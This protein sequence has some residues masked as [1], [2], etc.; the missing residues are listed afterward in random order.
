MLLLSLMVVVVACVAPAVL[1]HDGMI[2]VKGG[3]FTMGTDD[4]Q[5]RDG[6]GPARRVKVKTFYLDEKPVVNEQFRS[7][8]RDTKYKTDAEKYGWSFVF[9]A[10]VADEVKSTIEQTVK[11][12]EWWL[13]VPK[14]YWRVP[15][16]KGSGLKNKMDYPVTQVSWNDA[17]AYCKW[18]GKRLPTEAEWEFAVRGGLEGKVYPWGNKI[19]KNRM[20]TWEGKFPDENSV[21]DGHHGLAPADA[22]GP[23]NKFGF[24]NMLGNGWEWTADEFQR[25]ANAPPQ[26]SQDKQYVLRGGS[27]L[28]SIDGKT[29]HKVRVTTRMGNTPD[30]GSDNLTFRC[31][32]SAA[33]DEL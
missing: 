28:D 17:D 10:F 26:Q 1:C 14:A 21:E 4:P 6:E 32:A 2:K 16:G 3:S 15:F 12:A 13:P 5:Q 30:S 31:A 18:A 7:F 27:Y 29:N 22:Y 9:H 25:P 19:E 11:G 20:N 24:Y 8:I 33:K 23:Q